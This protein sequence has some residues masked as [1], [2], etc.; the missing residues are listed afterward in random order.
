MSCKYHCY[1][2]IIKTLLLA[3]ISLASLTSFHYHGNITIIIVIAIMYGSKS[4]YRLLIKKKKKK[5]S[6]NNTLFV[7]ANNGIR[8]PWLPESNRI[9]I[10]YIILLYTSYTV[11][12]NNNTEMYYIL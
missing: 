4:V 11:S 5:K 3:F 12:A 1:S 9:S 7:P 10:S 2:Y 6:Q 8:N